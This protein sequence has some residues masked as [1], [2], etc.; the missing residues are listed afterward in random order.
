MYNFRYLLGIAEFAAMEAGKAIM[1]VYRSG[2]FGIMMKPGDSP[3]TNADRNAHAIL[4][5]HLEKTNL[6]ILSE[7]GPGIEFVKRRSWEYFWLID[8]LDGTKEFISR[9]GE[10]TVNIALVRRDM[11]AG[12]VIYVPCIDAMYTGWRDTGVYKKEKGRLTS[13]PPRAE[14]NRLE[15]LLQRGHIT[16]AV[17]RSHLSEETKDF[18]ARFKNVSLRSSGSSLKFMMLL[19]DQADIYPRFGTTMEW[20]TAAAHAILNISN[21]GV[22]QQDMSAELRY[23]KPELR[24]P[25]FIA[26]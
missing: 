6:P 16:V 15:N 13:F 5:E 14:R 20:D 3:V 25:Y 24:N 4:T 23:N 19:E 17:S 11:P 21:R 2:E 18:T 8:P 22:Y 10:F 7:E 9:N 26:L 12:G 1:E